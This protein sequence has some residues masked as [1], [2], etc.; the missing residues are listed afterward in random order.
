MKRVSW[1]YFMSCLLLGLWFG[2]TIAVDFF[3]VPAVF[4][5]V[6]NLGEAA[7]VGM[8]VFARF[9]SLEFI[10]SLTLPLLWILAHKF[11]FSSGKRVF[12]L[13]FEVVLIALAASYLFYFTPAITELSL[14]KANVFE[15]SERLG[16]EQSIASLHSIYIKLDS[17]KLIILLGLNYFIFNDLRNDLRDLRVSKQEE[18]L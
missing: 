1:A 11:N 8:K 18:T 15:E 10:L 14:A 16:L 13:L 9:N 17:L 12:I 6:S 5:S 2:A 7:A 4:Q 3:A